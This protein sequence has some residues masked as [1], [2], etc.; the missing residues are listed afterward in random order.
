[1]SSR[2]QH[3]QDEK[4]NSYAPPSGAEGGVISLGGECGAIAASTAGQAVAGLAMPSQDA[5][6]Q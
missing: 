6:L 3:T 2:S 1:M 4:V 5:F